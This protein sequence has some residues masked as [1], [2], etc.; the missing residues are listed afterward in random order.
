MFEKDVFKYDFKGGYP[1]PPQRGEVF[2]PLNPQFYNPLSMETES[3][4]K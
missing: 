1:S 4:L 2:R 3:Q